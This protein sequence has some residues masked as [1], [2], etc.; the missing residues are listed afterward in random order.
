MKKLLVISACWAA[1]LLSVKAASVTSGANVT[2]NGTFFTGNGGWSLGTNAAASDLVNGTYQPEGHQWN[3]DS[4]WWNGADHP[5]NNIVVSLSDWATITDFKVQADD[6]D[7]YRIEYW[8]MD[9]LWHVGWDIP[10]PGGWGLITSSTNLGSS[11]TTNALRFTATGGD[12][13][14]AVSQIEANGRFLSTTVPENT[15]TLALLGGSL[16][17]IALMRRFK[18]SR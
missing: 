8:G 4:V 7:T 9:S 13:F 6:N 10:A 1:L 12:G 17:L 5:T 2:L 11:I 15:A 18:V 16:G 14:Y 3:F